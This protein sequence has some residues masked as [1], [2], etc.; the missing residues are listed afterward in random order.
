MNI[1]IGIDIGGTCIKAGLFTENGKRINSAKVLTPQNSTP[2]V[3]IALLTE[4]ISYLDP[5]CQA[6]TIGVGI[7]GVVDDS[8]QIVKKCLNLKNWIDVPFAHLL[9]FELN[10]RV[11][12]GNDANLACL[13][14]QWLGCSGQF[15]SV[16]FITIGTGIGCGISIDKKIV[17]GAHERT[18]GLGHIILYPNGIPCPCGNNG[19]FEQYVSA[20]AIKRRFGVNP[21]MLSFLALQNNLKAIE[22]WK[23]FGRD[24]G[25][26]L[27]TIVQLLDPEAIIIGGGISS[28]CQFFLPEA[29]TK[30][31]NNLFDNRPNLSILQANL[32]SEAG[33]FGAAFLAIKSFLRS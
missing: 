20:T 33:F 12:L 21:T 27:I 30:I 13:G 23:T 29:K 7:P 6:S 3:V 10:R 5:T 17:T 26:A 22:C 8:G 4:L 19:C 9:Q 28:A 14:E 11:I 32:G 16:A 24:F 31:H 1:V 25:I 15:N 18:G 2:N